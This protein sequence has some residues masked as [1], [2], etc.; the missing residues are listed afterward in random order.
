MA[1]ILRHPLPPGTAED[2]VSFLP[3][4]R[5]TKTSRRPPLVLHSIRGTFAV[6]DGPW[7]WITGPDSGGWTAGK[8]DA[9]SQL[10]HLGRDPGETHNLASTRPSKVRSLQTQLDLIRNTP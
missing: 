2:S 1:D 5:G 3:A 8:F 9:P 4:L 10:F 7:K 6:R